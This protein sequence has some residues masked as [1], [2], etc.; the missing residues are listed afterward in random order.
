[1]LGG[2][3]GQRFSGTCKPH[4][5]IQALLPDGGQEPT[6][7]RVV[8]CVSHPVQAL[9]RVGTSSDCT[10]PGV[11]MRTSVTTISIYKPSGRASFHF[12]GK[13]YQH[14][15]YARKHKRN[16]ITVSQDQ[17]SWHTYRPPRYGIGYHC[18]NG[19]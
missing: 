9:P 16:N 12:L 5:R 11:P 17:D 14:R 2:H 7:D 8:R 15:W 4:R 13:L 18:R 6:D 3:Y 19:Q 10:G 1:M